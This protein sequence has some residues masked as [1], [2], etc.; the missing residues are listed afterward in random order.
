MQNR[1][2]D[3]INTQYKCSIVIKKPK[4][5]LN[6][7]FSWIVAAIENEKLG[8][9]STEEDIF[10]LK[11]EQAQ[12]TKLKYRQ[13][14]KSDDN[15]GGVMFD[16]CPYC[17]DIPYYI[18]GDNLTQINLSSQNYIT[19]KFF[20]AN[21][22]LMNCTVS[23]EINSSWT[24]NVTLNN[25]DDIYT[26]YNAGEKNSSGGYDYNNYVLNQGNTCVIEPNDEIEV[27]MSDWKGDIHCVFTGYVSNV[28]MQ[29]DGLV[30]TVSLQCN[31]ILK[32]LTWHY[33]NVQAS[34][35]VKEA[36]G[37][38]LSVY[39]ENYQDLTL[40]E[41]M[42]YVLGETYCDIFK[43]DSFLLELV[44]IYAPAYAKTKKAKTKQEISQAK[45]S[46]NTAI[47]GLATKIQEE[48]RKY[49]GEIEYAPDTTA[50][51][52]VTVMGETQYVQTAIPECQIAR[53]CTI[54]ME[55]LIYP[56]EV[57]K[58]IDKK[59][60]MVKTPFK[61]YDQGELAFKIEGESQPAWSWIIR[62]GGYDYL[63]S[64]MKRN[65][66]FIRTIAD[67][68]QY[69]FYADCTGTV[70]FR[71]PNLTLPRTSLLNTEKPLYDSYIKDNYW[72]TRDKEQYFTQFTSTVNDN[73][74]FTRINVIGQWP[75]TG[76]TNDFLKSAGYAS[77][78]WLNKY[79]LRIMPSVTRPGL[80]NQEACKAY[81]QL[82]LWKNNIN[83]ELCNASCILNSNY[84]VGLP[85]YVE[86]H[87]AVWYV[88]RVQH[89]F[90]SGGQCTTTLT[91]TYKRTPMCFK[92]DLQKYL[93]D[94]KNWGKLSQE[95]VDYIKDNELMLTWGQM[96]T[97][98][99]PNVSKKEKVDKPDSTTNT[100]Y[101][102]IWQAI[103]TNLYPLALELQ[104]QVDNTNGITSNLGKTVTNN[105]TKS[106]KKVE[107]K[108][109]WK[110]GQKDLQ[111]RT[112]V[113]FVNETDKGLIDW[114]QMQMDISGEKAYQMQQET[115]G[116]FVTAGK[117]FKELLK[118]G[119]DWFGSKIYDAIAPVVN[120][121][122][123]FQ[124]NI[125]EEKTKSAIE[126]IKKT[127]KK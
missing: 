122:M 30:K 91:L 109:Y 106:K 1:K 84:T 34:F 33:F 58:K 100:D 57:S 102:F 32:R 98:T 62:S 114:R 88:G 15:K 37:T 78:W 68:V 83:Y 61:A 86:R 63:F 115:V 49:L 110:Y 92:K 80:T 27:Y 79:G 87:L 51:K 107:T 113:E 54:D 82:L 93:T 105:H 40:N 118:K 56:E 99:V 59:Y 46:Q 48:I 72:L 35:D 12:E 70:Y 42:S 6:D 29:D 73:K 96:R 3:L 8:T 41:V 13:F 123:E 125:Q 127:T 60:N 5:T 11:V 21:D 69:E 74:I 124:Q 120:A 26:L 45:E 19:N 90:A 44:K 89:T 97:D 50:L 116:R 75:E 121:D 23:Q 85:I 65:D 53:K 4:Y 101:F 126:R 16:P 81:A 117:E 55:Q 7:G 119:G 52:K 64:N 94:N 14:L 2:I 103:P 77:Q 67:L 111:G 28:A 108:E 39:A 95:E 20:Y 76:Y 17:V 36:R 38:T 22:R 25:T 10:K 31:D 66:N 112:Y 104:Q 47:Q 18:V 43:R 71:P 9:K 24:C